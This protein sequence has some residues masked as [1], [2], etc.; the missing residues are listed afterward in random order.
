MLACPH[1]PKGMSVVHEIRIQAK[2][3][4]GMFRDIMG[5]GLGTVDD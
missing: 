2:L 1:Y 3:V 5:T 4:D